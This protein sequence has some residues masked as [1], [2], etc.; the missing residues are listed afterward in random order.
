MLIVLLIVLKRLPKNKPNLY[1]VRP[2]QYIQITNK[3]RKALNSRKHQSLTF[4]IDLNGM[5]VCF[6]KDFV[7]KNVD[8]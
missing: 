8:L 1:I 3:I 2:E 5:V 7:P 6:F 4:F